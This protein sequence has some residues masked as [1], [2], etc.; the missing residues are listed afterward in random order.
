MLEAGMLMLV[1]VGLG[2]AVQAVDVLIVFVV[3][4]RL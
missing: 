2:V 3:K 4:G 1:G